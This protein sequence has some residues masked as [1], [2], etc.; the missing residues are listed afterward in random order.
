MKPFLLLALALTTNLC[1]ALLC[2]LAPWLCAGQTSGPLLTVTRQT[3]GPPALAT[4]QWPVTGPVKGLVFISHGY[5]EHL[6]PYYDGV[7]KHT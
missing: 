4:Y 2:G 6:R 3:S 1:Q 7:G 5:A